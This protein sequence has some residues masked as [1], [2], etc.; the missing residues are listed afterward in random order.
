MGTVGE[1]RFQRYRRDRAGGIAQKPM[2]VSKAQDA[3][4]AGRVHANRFPEQTL[5]LPGA[6]AEPSCDL[7]DRQGRAEVLLHQQQSPANP[8]VRDG[9]SACFSGGRGLRLAL[10]RRAGLVDQHDMHRLLGTGRTQMTLDQESGQ[11]GYP[12]TTGTGDAVTVHDIELICYRLMVGEFLQV[13]AVMVPANAAAPI[14]QQ[15]EPVDGEAAGADTDQG[16]ALR[17]RQARV[18][19]S[20]YVQLQ[21]RMKQTAHHD[22][23]ADLRLVL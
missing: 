11:I 23:V 14:S 5:E 19:D 20:S 6:D 8:V 16:N 21:S 22:D 13:V 2:A 15:Y 12:G 9:A 7:L 3:V 18:N 4:E 1:A 10:S 17:H